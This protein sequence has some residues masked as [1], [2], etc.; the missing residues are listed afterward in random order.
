MSTA[1]I[2]QPDFL[3]WLGFFHRLL[4]ADVYIALDCVQ[5]VSRTSRSWTHRDKIKT[6][7]GEKW[8]TL[9]VR[10]APLGTQI[11]R[12]ELSDAADWRAANLSLLRENYRGAAHFD[13]IYTRIEALYAMPCTLLA[14]FNLASIRLLLELFAIDIP[15]R[16]ASELEPAGASNERLVDILVKAG[17]GCYLSGLGARDYFRAEP[18]AAAGIEVRWQEFRHPVYPQLHGDFIPFLS[19]IDMLFNCGIERSRDILRSC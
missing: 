13:A 15:I 5:F 1:V 2:H 9:G 8:L 11:R 17:A 16:L 18:F 7:R 19:S 14:D 3:S 6:P 4:H 12:I 10:R